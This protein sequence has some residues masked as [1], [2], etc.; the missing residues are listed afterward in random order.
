M[1]MKPDQTHQVTANSPAQGSTMDRRALLRAGVASTPVL[2]TLASQ[3]VAA[4]T[5][6][7]VASSFVSGATFASR[8]PGAT[9]RCASTD[10][11]TWRNKAITD[12]TVK[13]DLMNTKVSS[14]LGTTGSQYNASSLYTVLTTGTAIS[15]TGELGVLQH[16]IALY[17]NIYTNTANNPLSGSPKA[18]FIASTAY[19]AEVWQ[20]FKANGDQYKLTGSGI[21][22]DASKVVA[23]VRKLISA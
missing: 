22:W 13:T 15:Q 8:N 4:A 20:N 11:E 9:T 2:M 6:C 12:T 16:L 10:C 14:A 23:W 18:N 1:R 5:T 7:T 21:A 19:V 17:L 3:P